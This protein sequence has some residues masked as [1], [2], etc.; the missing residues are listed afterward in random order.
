MQF[1][2]WRPAVER[3]GLQQHCALRG[4]GYLQQHALLML[5]SL[6]P[7]SPPGVAAAGGVVSARRGG[8]RRELAA[9][10]DTGGRG[11]GPPA[12]I[13]VQGAGR[14]RGAGGL[15][16]GVV[17]RNLK[18]DLTSHLL[19]LAHSTQ[20]GHLPLNHLQAP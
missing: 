14:G 3:A 10:G 20:C 13:G 9:G 15:S 8:A 1:S 18:G 11:A 19:H 2:V 16:D 4:M 17:T 5:L 6:A 7:S 12:G